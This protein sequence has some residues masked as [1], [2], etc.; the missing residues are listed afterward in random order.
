[1]TYHFVGLHI[2]LTHCGLTCLAHFEIIVGFRLAQVE[3]GVMGNY[4]VEL[5]LIVRREA[6]VGRIRK[7][8]FFELQEVLDDQ[9]VIVVF[10]VALV[11]DD[12]FNFVLLA[13]ENFLLSLQGKAVG[14]DAF[15]Q[16]KLVV[17]S[18]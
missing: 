8:D 3:Y 14:S 18:N 10:Q 2:N 4:F 11:V 12:C 7:T 6:R 17:T 15:H 5:D 13:H 9:R 16:V 1:M